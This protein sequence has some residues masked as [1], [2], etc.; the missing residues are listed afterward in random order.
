MTRPVEADFPIEPCAKCGT[1]VEVL[2]AEMG[3]LPV[4][5][6]TRANHSPLVCAL[7]AE[8]ERLRAEVAQLACSDHED[9]LYERNEALESENGALADALRTL[10]REM[11]AWMRAEPGTP[12]KYATGMALEDAQSAARL[13]LAALDG[14]SDD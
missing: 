9:R 14:G 2:P 8:N 1:S 3:L 7:R 5:V 10:L 12:D 6:A 13:L 11:V 4:E